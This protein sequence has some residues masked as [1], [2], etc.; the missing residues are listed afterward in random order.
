MLGAAAKEN[1]YII[2]TKHVS[3]Y[4]TKIIPIIY[5]NQNVIGDKILKTGDVRNHQN[6]VVPLPL[7]EQGE[8]VGERR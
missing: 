3:I 2:T 8:A 4:N 7:L 5:L 1:G 6:T